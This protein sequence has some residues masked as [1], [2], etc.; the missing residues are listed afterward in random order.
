M[1]VAVA[2]GTGVVGRFTAEAA[3]AAGHEVKVLSRSTGINIHSGDGLT[4]ALVG[5]DVIIDTTN[6]P[7]AD[8]TTTTE[9][10]V[11]A[12]NNLHHAGVEAGVG[13]LVVLSIVGIDEADDSYY[14]AKL[15]QER[16]A[17]SGHLPVTI[18]RTTQFHEFA[19]QIITW[20][21]NGFRAE[22]PN[23]RVQTVAART[24]GEALV[25]HAEEPPQGH[26][27]DLGGPEESSLP[28]LVRRFVEHHKIDIKIE[29]IESQFPARMLVPTYGARIEGPTFGQWLKGEDSRQMA[30]YVQ[31]ALG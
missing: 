4:E 27:P 23:H 20:S 2:G 29:P 25:R 19:A 10:F 28:T 6:P 8:E 24:V 11:T 1:K 15:A 7:P 14:R 21:S 5:V 22:I 3:I 9:F 18:L 31:K 12:T 26:V 17:R 30:L 13:H 16:C